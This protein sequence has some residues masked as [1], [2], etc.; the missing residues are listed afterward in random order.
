[1]IGLP[2]ILSLLR[3][4]KD[5]PYKIHIELETGMNRLGFPESELDE[6]IA[7]LRRIRRY[8]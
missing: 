3:T 1:M 4:E 2:Q 5:E 6:L 7:K 8:R